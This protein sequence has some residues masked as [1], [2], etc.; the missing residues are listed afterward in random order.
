MIEN[1]KAIWDMNKKGNFLQMGSL[2]K[3]NIKRQKKFMTEFYN[4]YE[5]KTKPFHEWTQHYFPLTHAV[6]RHYK[7]S[8]SKALT[9][10]LSLYGMAHAE[11]D[12]DI[13]HSR[14]KVYEDHDVVL[15]PLL[16]NTQHF[17]KSKNLPLTLE[18][19]EGPTIATFSYNQ[20]L[21]YAE[22]ARASYT[23]NKNQKA[24]VQ[25]M[26]S[27][28]Y[29][30][31]P[32]YKNTP[33]KKDGI[34]P[35]DQGRHAGY[36]FI[37][38]NEVIIS[39]RGTESKALSTAFFDLATDFNGTMQKNT[40]GAGRVH[41]GFERE[42]GRSHEY[43]L[44]ILRD[45]CKENDINY[46]DLNFVVTG[47]SLG[48]GM[49]TLFVDHLIHN[50]HVNPKHVSL[51][52][53]A[54]P[55]VG[56]QAFVDQL[57]QSME[58][59]ILRVNVANDIVTGICPVSGGYAHIGHTLDLTTPNGLMSAVTFNE[60]LMNTYIQ[61]LEDLN[62]TDFKARDINSQT[63]LSYT[64]K[65]LGAGLKTLNKLDITS[66]K[67][68]T[69]YN[70]YETHFPEHKIAKKEAKNQLKSKLNDL[71]LATN[72]LNDAIRRGEDSDSLKLYK[73]EQIKGILAIKELMNTLGNNRFVLKSLTKKEREMIL[74]L[75][76]SFKKFDK[77]LSKVNKIVHD[78]DVYVSLN[79]TCLNELNILKELNKNNSNNMNPMIE[80]AEK[81]YEKNKEILEKNR[82]A[83]E[84]EIKKLD[85]S[86]DVLI[87][88]LFKILK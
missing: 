50:L 36:V 33:Y 5:K 74:A 25:S 37:K 49:A 29:K 52:T 14:Q 4:L 65:V 16:R 55:R 70:D 18:L 21:S 48:A 51:I 76:H 27:K 6:R 8:L 67:L 19:E 82:Q 39:Y 7:Q 40:H 44:N 26:E 73:I 23:N 81:L 9:A 28:G 22:I 54:S 84:K 38:D 57:N 68:W 83:L 69:H 53:F 61:A 63:A 12:V 35:M 56:N 20:V 45:Y 31:Y 3:E 24:M 85:T 79:E 78:V 1:Q 59:R 2:Y 58:G 60:H 64:D 75:Q 71:T 34:K 11:V 66:W 42:L 77:Q 62:P 10:F 80:K 30:A 72:E 43:V 41:K 86:K 46:N 15:P 47:H 88:D 32:F 13:F 87:Q 17:E